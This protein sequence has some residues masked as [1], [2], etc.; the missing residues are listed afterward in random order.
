MYKML[1]FVPDSQNKMFILFTDID[2]VFLHVKNE[3]IVGSYLKK[4]YISKIEPSEGETV[5]LFDKTAIENLS[6]LISMI[7]EKGVTVGL[8]I[9]SNWRKFVKTTAFLR[10]EILKEYAIFKKIIDRT[11]HTILIDEGPVERLKRG[12]EIDVWLQEN[13]VKFNISNFLILDD[14]DD[15]ISELF[16]VNF[17]HCKDGLLSENDLE[18]ASALINSQRPSSEVKEEYPVNRLKLNM[19]GRDDSVR[20]MV[21]SCRVTSYMRNTFLKAILGK[22][23]SLAEETTAD[24]NNT[25]ADLIIQYIM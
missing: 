15:G 8:V 17:I 9:S 1:R 18:K 24:K 2:G 14:N 10:D 11:A 23:T 13:R 3:E 5:E 19:S 4:R 22:E 16:G 6:R 7:E 20:S 25:P 12:E 21:A